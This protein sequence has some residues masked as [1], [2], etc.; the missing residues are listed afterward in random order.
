MS[1]SPCPKLGPPVGIQLIAYGNAFLFINRVGFTPQG[2]FK[3]KM[4]ALESSL[5]AIYNV[6]M[7]VLYTTS[8]PGFGGISTKDP[9][10]IALYNY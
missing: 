1:I 9:S 2:F 4:K 5:L 10:F 7:I 3:V 6:Y 8:T